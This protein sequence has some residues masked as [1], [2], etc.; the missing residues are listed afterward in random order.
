MGFGIEIRGKDG[1]G[2][3]LVTDTDQNLIN[4]QVTA[5]GVASSLSSAAV[6]AG[7]RVFINGNTTA[8]QGN[9]I[10]A[11]LGSGYSV[12]FKKVTFNG[13]PA[14][15][16]HLSNISGTNVNVNYI[17][18][19]K[20]TDIANIGTN[21][22]IQLFTSG[23]AVAFDSRRC[24]T[25]DTFDLIDAKSPRSQYI[26]TEITT[27]GDAY[28][29]ISSLYSLITPNAES[30]VSGCTWNGSGTGAGRLR[31]LSFFS[32]PEMNSTDYFRNHNTLLLGKLR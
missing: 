31:Y 5:S 11:Q 28:L 22:G 4:Y 2:E 3:F 1:G 24:R 12:E 27:N 21:F 25:N 26:N 10:A 6:S 17:I 14:Q 20:M 30:N 29:E 15:N 16:N 7:G 8:A 19:S 18:I 32:I 13:S 9:V 23:S